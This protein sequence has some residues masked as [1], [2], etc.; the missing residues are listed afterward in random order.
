M[1]VYCKKCGL[2]CKPK[3]D[4]VVCEV[5]GNEME[6]VPREYLTS[7]GLM[8]ASQEK[9]EEFEAKIKQN[10]EYDE[11]TSSRKKKIIKENEEMRACEIAKKVDEYNSGA[12]KAHCPVCHSITLE[13]ISN[14]GKVVKVGVFGILGTGDIGKKYRCKACGYRF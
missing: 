11:E 10:A 6:T 4:T 5:C 2:I 7:S 8:F 13:K 14:V 1:L 12:V 9:R 3:K